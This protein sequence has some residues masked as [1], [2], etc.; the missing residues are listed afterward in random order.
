MF[1]TYCQAKKIRFLPFSLFQPVATVRRVSG[2]V[3]MGWV[4]GEGT[5]GFGPKQPQVVVLFGATGDLSRR[6]LIPG[7]FHLALAGF[8]PGCQIIGVSL[9]E[10]TR[11]EFIDQALDCR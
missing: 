10:L 6:K 1:P 11:E 3:T 7:L 5:E 8:I 4:H 2:G 9:D